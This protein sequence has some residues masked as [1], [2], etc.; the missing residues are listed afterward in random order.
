MAKAK[1]EINV[2]DTEKVK[3]FIAETKLVI[4]E[5]VMLRERIAELE[6]K[7]TDFD[8]QTGVA[9][10]YCEE[11][12]QDNDRLR[13]RI[14][15]LGAHVE[16]WRGQYWGATMVVKSLRAEKEALATQGEEVEG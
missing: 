6:A 16:Y 2:M 13:K 10:V 3:H 8:R 11:Q 5:N 7:V 12:Q 15:E 9:R 1:I 14:G 4:A